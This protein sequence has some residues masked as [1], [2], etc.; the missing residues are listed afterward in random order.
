LNFTSR[1]DEE[2]DDKSIV[3][4]RILLPSFLKKLRLLPDKA[5]SNSSV[6]KL[7]STSVNVNSEPLVFLKS[8]AINLI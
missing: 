5:T 1:P 6:E 3:L 4:F 8:I 2:I 7:S